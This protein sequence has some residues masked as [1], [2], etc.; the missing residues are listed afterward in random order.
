MNSF[1]KVRPDRSRSDVTTTTWPGTDVRFRETSNIKDGSNV[2]CDMV[3]NASAGNAARRRAVVNGGTGI[4]KAWVNGDLGSSYGSQRI[5]EI[6]QV[7]HYLGHQVG[8]YQSELG[9]E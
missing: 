1:A 4:G 8:L 5:D 2:T 7:C 6:H 9:T 3:V